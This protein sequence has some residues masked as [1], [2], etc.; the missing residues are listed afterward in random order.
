MRS[1]R[2]LA[3]LWAA[4]AGLLL[5]LAACST[6]SAQR[7]TATDT[8]AAAPGT[9]TEFAGNPIPDVVARVQPS[10]VA[11]LTD[12]GQGSGVVWNTEGV[13]VTN[14]HV[15]AGARQVE[16]AFADGQRVAAQLVATDPQ[17]DLAV[18]RSSRG[19][20]PAATFADTLPRV[21]E[22]AIAMGNPLGFEN[23]V[24]AGII[25]G[26]GRSI[27]GAAQEA[28]AL[29][30]LIQ[31]D[32]AISPG[33][34]GRALVGAD[35]RVV[36]INVAYIPPSAGAE[37]LGFAIPSPTVRHVVTQLLQDGRVRH[38]FFGV[39]PAHLTPE[40]AERFD[41]SEER[42]VLVLDVTPGSPA[43]GA[44]IRPGDVL[45]RAGDRRLETVEDFLAVLRGRNPGDSLQ[46]TLS[47][48][49][50]QQQVTVRLGERPR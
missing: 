41:L 3:G 8:T 37:S 18:V 30:D 33:N 26:L 13:V 23:T 12:R 44:G 32:A 7:E 34:S 20:L 40:I 1:D 35:G 21:G 2:F 47:R 10:V 14:D 11:V 9:A 48:G 38:P 36:G 29:V 25:S 22:L 16:I 4:L 19:S 50:N 28:P 45:V 17:T 42:G 49:G 46:V 31:T 43:A 6:D 24:T 5:A 15:V 27:P 39:R